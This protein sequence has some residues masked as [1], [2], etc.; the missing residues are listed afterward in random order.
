MILLLKGGLDE[1]PPRLATLAKRVLIALTILEY[2]CPKSQ[3][4][5]VMKPNRHSGAAGTP[6]SKKKE[7]RI[8][9]CFSCRGDAWLDR[10][11]MRKLD[12]IFV[13]LMARFFGK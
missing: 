8:A 7:T 11:H 1:P 5:Q 4:F 12:V 9:V 3:S 10:K 2:Q 13:N 6:I